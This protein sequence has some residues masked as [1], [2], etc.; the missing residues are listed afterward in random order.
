MGWRQRRVCPDAPHRKS[1]ARPGSNT[2]D[3]G[4][5]VLPHKKRGG[6]SPARRRECY[7]A[8][9]LALSYGPR[10]R[11]TL[12]AHLWD[13]GGWPRAE[14]KLAHRESGNGGNGSSQTLSVFCF[15][16]EVRG[17][18]LLLLPS[19]LLSCF[20]VLAGSVAAVGSRTPRS[21]AAPRQGTGTVLAG[22]TGR[23]TFPPPGGKDHGAQ[24]SG[25]RPGNEVF[26]LRDKTGTRQCLVAV[27]GIRLQCVSTPTGHQGRWHNTLS[28]SSATRVWRAEPVIRAG[29]VEGGFDLE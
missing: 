24:R 23:G 29:I 8:W 12:W 28:A 14:R 2:S 9:D 15:L 4:N 6:N 10:C 18:P 11:E 16:G 13:G 20:R 7:R 5:N 27:T 3:T 17:D 26:A 21:W 22:A 25:P 19:G 1:P